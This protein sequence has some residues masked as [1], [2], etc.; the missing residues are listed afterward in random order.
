[1]TENHFDSRPW[2]KQI[3]LTFW[4]F[5]NLIVNI[6]DDDQNTTSKVRKKIVL[7]Q[8]CKVLVESEDGGDEIAWIGDETITLTS[9]EVLALK[10]HP[11]AV[12]NAINCLVFN[13][14]SVLIYFNNYA[15][16]CATNSSMKTLELN[17]I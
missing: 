5:T 13:S 12:D 16:T 3:E 14:S 10:H 11:L 17:K 1:M 15:I 8:N 7:D 2:K 9:E 4:A 6:E